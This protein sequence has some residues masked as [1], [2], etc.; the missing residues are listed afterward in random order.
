[1]GHRAVRGRTRRG[2][3]DLIMD[4][5]RA[6]PLAETRNRDLDH[7]VMTPL[8]QRVGHPIGQAHRSLHHLDRPRHFDVR[9]DPAG[10]MSRLAS[11]SRSPWIRASIRRGGRHSVSS[12]SMRIRYGRGGATTPRSTD[13]FSNVSPSSRN[14]VEPWPPLLEVVDLPDRF[15]QV[16]R[17]VREL[18]SHVGT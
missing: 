2:P 8:Q 4:L 14:S 7:A 6:Q 11:P 5:R 13:P 9:A 1:M 15:P 12:T 17:G 10:W 18:R 16:R 3:L